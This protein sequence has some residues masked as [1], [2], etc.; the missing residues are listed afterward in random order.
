MRPQ[1]QR[2]DQPAGDAPVA[3][4][5]IDGH[6]ADDDGFPTLLHGGAPDDTPFFQRDLKR[7]DDVVDIVRRESATPQE[8]GNFVA[9]GAGRLTQLNVF[10][11]LHV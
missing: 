11:D 7:I 2:L 4:H 10:G 3:T 8:R 5:R 9:I 6:R 1:Q